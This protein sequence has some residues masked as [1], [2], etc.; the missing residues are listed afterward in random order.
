[1]SDREIMDSKPN[2]TYPDTKVRKKLPD[3]RAHQIISFFKSGVRILGYFL[4]LVDL[5]V[6]VTFLILSE[7]VGIIEELV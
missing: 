6:A 3:A 1:M 7:M 5:E 4:L 2:W